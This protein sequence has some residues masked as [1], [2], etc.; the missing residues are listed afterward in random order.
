MACLFDTRG[1]GDKVNEPRTHQFSGGPPPL[2]ERDEVDIAATRPVVSQGGGA[3]HLETGDSPRQNR[4]PPAGTCSRS[5]RSLSRSQAHTSLKP[6]NGSAF[7][8]K[9]QR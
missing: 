9:Q 3:N 2:E 7:S 6:H 4:V 1:P 5:V 8:G